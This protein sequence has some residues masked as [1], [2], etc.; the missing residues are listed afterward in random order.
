MSAR[1]PH[2]ILAE[3]GRELRRAR[4]PRRRRGRRLA[5]GASVAIASAIAFAVAVLAPGGGTRP[6]DA[7]AAARQA[8]NPV[9]VVLHYRIRTDIPGEGIDRAYEET[10]SAQDPQRWRMKSSNLM[11]A[12][13]T[14][15]GESSYGGGVARNYSNGRL[16]VT[17][18]YKDYTPQTRLPTIFSQNGGDPDADLRSLLTAGKLIDQGEM[19][20]GGRT[21][22]RLVRDDG[23][24]RLV[25]DV[26]PQTFVP[27]GGSM[28]YRTPGKT[29]IPAHTLNY[30]VEVF[31]RLAISPETEQLL[32]FTPPAGTRTVTRTAADIHR[33]ARE[34]R[35][36]RKR[37]KVA[38][39][40]HRLRCPTAEP[41]LR[42]S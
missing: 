19:Q 15:A 22:R 14:Y 41:K 5:L 11:G 40:N 27:L 13:V 9:G 26:D 23:L 24:R 10:W 30:T 31:E 21:V 37:C 34:H 38:G 32:T 39:R 17:T 42:G 28:T 36:W 29:K 33:W 4:P 6:V 3:L 1:E 7:I 16:V 2:E 25:F 35:A 8:V 20:A 18:G 12:K